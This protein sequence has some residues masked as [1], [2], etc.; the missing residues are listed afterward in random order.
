MGMS[1]YPLGIPRKRQGM[2]GVRVSSVEA[3][4]GVT[5]TPLRDMAFALNQRPMLSLA[6]HKY[7]SGH[8]GRHVRLGRLRE[9]SASA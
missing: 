8:P 6:T 9:Q 2:G 7:P 1:L 4:H 5:I 3:N